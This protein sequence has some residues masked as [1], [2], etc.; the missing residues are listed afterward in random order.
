MTIIPE[1]IYQ[2]FIRFN[3]PYSYAIWM[4]CIR[5]NIYSGVFSIEE[6]MQINNEIL[7]EPPTQIF[8]NSDVL[9]HPWLPA[10]TS[11]AQ[12][13]NR[14]DL[15]QPR[16]VTQHDHIKQLINILNHFGVDTKY[17][18]YACYDWLFSHEG[19]ENSDRLANTLKEMIEIFQD[20]DN[21][22]T[23]TEKGTASDEDVSKYLAD[24]TKTINTIIE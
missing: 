2:S 3:D 17:G 12:H 19:L 1:G 11:I 24:I 18:K 15:Y 7:F 10:G 8:L 22:V 4:H 23:I 6:S 20:Y 9:Y 13:V 14:P 5:Q 21:Y 16:M